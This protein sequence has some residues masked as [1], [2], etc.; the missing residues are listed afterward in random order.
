MWFLRVVCRSTDGSVVKGPSRQQG[1]RRRLQ[2]EAEE[3]HGK[4]QDLG[5]RGRGGD[6]RVRP[7]FDQAAER[8]R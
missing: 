5:S 7:E 8:D 6:E 4:L 3:V 2:L 1:T